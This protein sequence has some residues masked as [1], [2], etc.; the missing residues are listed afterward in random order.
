MHDIILSCPP[1]MGLFVGVPNVCIKHVLNTSL[2]CLFQ[3]V[4]M[5][6]LNKAL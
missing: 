6:I 1:G 2:L 5:M 3:F 4:L